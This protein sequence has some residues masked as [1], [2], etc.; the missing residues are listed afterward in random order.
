MAIAVRD[1][2]RVALLRCIAAVR[3]P[4]PRL[5]IL[6]A[7]DVGPQSHD[8]CIPPD[9]FADQLRTLAAD[10]W[11]VLPLAEALQSGSDRTVALCFDDGYEGVAVHAR[12]L[13]DRY[14]FRATVFACP[15]YAGRPPG[16]AG[17]ED[18]LGAA[19][20][21]GRTVRLMTPAEMAELHRHGWEIGAHT[22][23][24]PDLR[25][26][27]YADA[28]AEIAN[29]RRALAEATGGPVVSFCYPYG[30][31]DARVTRLVA[32]EGFTAA[33]G[34]RLGHAGRGSGQFRLPRLHLSPDVDPPTLRAMLSPLFPAYLA[35]AAVARRL[36]GRPDPSESGRPS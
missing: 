11:A 15:G 23:T 6:Y 12:P 36:A 32:D 16:W 35:A 2:A 7:H 29:S 31:A 33:C 10:G 30:A 24:H 14:G 34:T 20:T 28:R 21:I 25:R 27:T 5:V 17:A 19:A 13:L 3:R 8:L 1:W 9:T 4:T 18:Y 22:V 26:L